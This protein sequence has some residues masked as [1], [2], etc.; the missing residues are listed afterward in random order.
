[1]DISDPTTP[2]LAGSLQDNSDLQ[3]AG[4]IKVVGNYAYVSCYWADAF[5]IV[6]I[7]N[8]SSPSKV[9]SLKQ[10]GGNLDGAT[11]LDVVGNHA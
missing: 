9:G 5:T 8:P 7:S 3:G 10:S 4:A 11:G 6:D 1:M 2:T